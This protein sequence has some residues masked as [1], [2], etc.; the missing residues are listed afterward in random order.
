VSEA[1]P[2]SVAQVQARDKLWT[3]GKDKD[4]SG[5]AGRGDAGRTGSDPAG[6]AGSG[7]GQIWTPG[8]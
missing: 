5:A 1:K 2:I 7:S 8:N 6:P 3:P 4:P